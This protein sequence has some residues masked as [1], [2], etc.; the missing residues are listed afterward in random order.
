MSVE[1]STSEYDPLRSGVHLGD[2]MVAALRRHADR[3]VLELGGTVLTG[4]QMAD[5]TSRY[6]QAFES[7]GAGAGS[8]V[9]LLALNRPE[10]LLVIGAG[11]TQGWRRTALHPLGS[12]DDHAYVLAD[13][14][15][16]TLVIDPVPMFVERALALVE[17]VGSLEQVLTLGPVPEALAGVGRDVIAEADGFEPIPLV[18]TPL[19]P[20]HIVSIT[21]TGGTTGKPKGVIGTAQAM[22]TMTQIQL[23]EWEWPEN[24]RFLMCTPLSHAGAA[25]F[26]PTLM[27]GGT[28]IVL[29]KF[30]P[31]EVLRVIEEKKISATMLVPSM[32]YA[33]L[34][35]PDS[36]TRDLSSLQTVYYGASPINPV[37]LAEAIERFGPIFAQYYGQSEAPMVISYLG[38]DDHPLPGGDP[39]RLSSCGRPSAF[40]RTALLGP[41]DTPVAQ[42]EPGEICVAGPLLAGG[43]WGLPEQTAEAF[44]DGWLRTGDV[45][46]ADEDGFWYIVDRTKDMIVTGGFNVFP[47]EV[48]DVVAEHPSVAQAGVI[49]VPD[50]K[51]G[52]AVTAVV[53]LRAEAAADAAAKA[54]IVAEIQESVKT[55]KG[56]VQSP[57]Q[58]LFVDALPL[59]A[60]G[61]PDKKALRARF[62]ETA[63]R[64][65][66]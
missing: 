17:R 42:G 45:A 9:G 23:A 59:T 3:N 22:A 34:D 60:L 49:G 66:G 65:V 61:K 36:R 56:A 50:D 6:V 47:R 26:V 13:A 21:Y 41:D 64:G 53:V 33:L 16:T 12:L 8:A 18:S 43:Y 35:H 40:L 52:E 51:W 58:V 38:K 63:E 24:P 10:V 57:K 25:F 28:M 48:E 37:R 44:R 7:L 1:T 2:L 14:G 29:A 11:Q 19:P 5:A 31:A 39:R 15:V 46:R 54:T 32:L 4:R 27:K 20:D 62:W 30:D 55:R